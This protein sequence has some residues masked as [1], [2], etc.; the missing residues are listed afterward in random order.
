MDYKDLRQKFVELSGRYDLIKAN[1]TDSGAD[2][3]INSGQKML[4]RMQDTGKAQARL[5]RT[6]AANTVVVYT[7]GLRAIKSVWVSNADGMTQLEKTSIENLRGYYGKKLSDIT[8]GTPANYAP[9][10]LRPYPDTTVAADVAGL[11]DIEDLILYVAA[12]ATGHW[13]YNGIIIAPPP[14]TVYTLSLWGLFYSPTL[15]ATLS[16]STWTQTKSFWS[17]EHPDILLIASLYKLEVFYRNS[18]GAKDWENALNKDMTGIDFGFVEEDVSG[19]VSEMG[20]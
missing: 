17:E 3:F 7:V 15:S 4:D 19:D 10:V 9:A 5:T 18:E 8:A 14:S 16:G 13:S 12:G 1:G 11:Y 6:L 20:G 2:F